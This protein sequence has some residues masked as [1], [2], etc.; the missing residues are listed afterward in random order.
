MRFSERAMYPFTGLTRS[1]PESFSLGASQSGRRHSGWKAIYDTESIKPI[2][3]RNIS[4]HER[5]SASQNYLDYR[6]AHIEIMTLRRI[7]G[8]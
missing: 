7:L 5:A 8:G 3:Y 2:F 1:R 6:A 4:F